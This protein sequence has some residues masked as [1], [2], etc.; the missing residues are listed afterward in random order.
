MKK[1]LIKVALLAIAMFCII[2]SLAK[3]AEQGEIAVQT[4]TAGY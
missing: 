3:L 1:T 2:G 4:V